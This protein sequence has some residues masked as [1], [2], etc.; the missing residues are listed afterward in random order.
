MERYE[1]WL[2][3]TYEEVQEAIR[4]AENEEWHHLPAESVENVIYTA[5]AH[6]VEILSERVKWYDD[7][8]RR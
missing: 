7:N 6:W 8:T 4:Q 5:L 2:K 1:R 3:K